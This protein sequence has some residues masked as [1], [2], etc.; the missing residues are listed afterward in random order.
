LALSACGGPDDHEYDC[1]VFP[2]AA[3]SPHILPWN[4]GETHRAFP[5]AANFAPSPQMYALDLEMPIGTQILAIRD[6]TVVRVVENFSNDDHVFGHENAVYVEH[7]DGTVARYLH[8]TTDGALV[9]VGDAVLQGEVIALSGNSGQSRGPHLHLDVTADCCAVPPNY[10]S[11]PAGQTQPLAFRNAGGARS[12][13]PADQSC[14][15]RVRVS[16]TALP[17]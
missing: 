6:G 15:L 12:G 11:L 10:D 5:H 14:G 1:A 7:A 13:V 17:Y 4:V 3:Q 9:T 8:L 2:E 16:Y